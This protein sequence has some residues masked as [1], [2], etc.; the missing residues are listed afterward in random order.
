MD[1]L[2]FIS[3]YEAILKARKIPKMQFYKDCS[4]SDAAVSQWRKGKTKPAMTTIN[5]ISDY[6]GISVSYLLGG[7]TTED[8]VIFSDGSGYGGGFGCGSGFGNG[9]GYGG[10]FP[11]DDSEKKEKPTPVSESGQPVNIVKIA[12]RD[13]SFV[14]K[15]LSDKELQALKAFVDL[16]S[17]ANDDL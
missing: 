12:G 7:A 4:I 15:R 5:R 3:R 13:G 9:S 16:L 6:L 11:T 17:D 8:G 14:E 1:A 10:P 2:A